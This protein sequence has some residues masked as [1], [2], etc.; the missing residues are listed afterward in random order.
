MLP[1]KGAAPL[2]PK[3][4]MASPGLSTVIRLVDNVVPSHRKLSEFSLSV[5]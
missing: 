2:P 1:A 3:Q 5:P 4:H